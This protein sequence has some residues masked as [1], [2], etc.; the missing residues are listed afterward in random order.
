MT[1]P[2]SVTSVTPLAAGPDSGTPRG[3]CAARE[4]NPNPLIKSQPGSCGVL[5]PLISQEHWRSLRAKTSKLAGAE[6]IIRPGWRAPA[7]VAAL[8]RGLDRTGLEAQS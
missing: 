2:S 7:G 5:N 8:S 3:L 4:S 6:T 1:A